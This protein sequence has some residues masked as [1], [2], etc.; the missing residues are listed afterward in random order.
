MNSSNNPFNAKLEEVAITKFNGTDKISIMPQV[1]E[2]TLHQSIFSPIMKADMVI[3]DGIGLMDNYPWSGE[4][5]VEV[6]LIQDGEEQENKGSG[7]KQFHR[8]LT[9]I[10]SAIKDIRVDSD[11]RTTTYIIEL[12]SYDAFVNA[13]TRVSH[14]YYE[15]IETMIEKVYKDYIIKNRTDPKPKELKIFKDTDKVRKLVV[16]NIKPFDAI[17]WFCKYAVSSNPEKYYTHMFYETID[18]YTFKALQKLTFRGREDAD[19]LYAA[20]Q[21][22][23]IYVGDISLVKNNPQALQQLQARGFS[24]SRIINDMKIN[25]RY[26]ALEKIVGGYFEN[27]LVEINMLKNDYKITRKELNYKDYEFNTINPGKG[28]NTKDYI[29]DVKKEYEEPETS[30][31]IRYI[32]NNYDDENQPSFRDKFGRSAMSFIAFQQVDL[33]IAV[34]TNLLMRVGD[35]IFVE[36]PELHGF[37]LNDADRYL[38]GFYIVSEI[39]TV[40]KQGGKSASYVRINRDSFT[41]NLALRHDFAFSSNDPQVSKTNPMGPR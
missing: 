9:F 40:M 31:R 1:A 15:D 11:G 24:D 3:V 41:N 2:F 37:N 10:I 6:E 29:E 12:A 8:I 13:K 36:L 39:K 26:S 16:P 33:S 19:A 14:A 30:A 5:K 18:N 34:N 7:Q 22:K 35:C 17:A 4:E 20:A 27:E 28:Y 32:I 38:S 23:Y 25:K 21:E